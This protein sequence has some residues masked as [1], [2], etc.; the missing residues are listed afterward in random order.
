MQTVTK[1]MSKNIFVIPGMP[2]TGSTFL[3]HTFQQHPSIFVP[4]RKETNYFCA[5][6]EKDTN[7]YLQQFYKKM[8]SQQTGVDIS[9]VCFLHPDSTYRI[10]NF[11]PD[12]KVILGIRLPSDWIL[13]MYSQISSFEWKPPS[14]QVF[15]EK[16]DWIRIVEGKKIYV[17]FSNEFII[18]T[19]EQY[20]ETFNNNLL[21][22]QYEFFQKAPLS[23]IR[24]IE[25]F[26]DLP[27]YFNENN[28]E[29]TIVNAGNR[30][31]IKIISYLLTQKGVVPALKLLF[32]EHILQ[33]SKN[34][35]DKKVGKKLDGKSKIYTPENIELAKKILF[36]EDAYVTE[37]FSKHKIQCGDGSPFEYFL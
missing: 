1:D 19:I 7:W 12:I 25:D 22:Y 17:D 3:Y 35:F 31:N 18:R 27:P 15:V 37:L 9:P 16:G 29:N 33:L 34:F 36:K 4:Y 26:I 5:Y 32:P 20:K 2:R 14:F 6:F 21:L 13:S 28:F 30:R 10:K 23:V 11:N 8:K 24:S